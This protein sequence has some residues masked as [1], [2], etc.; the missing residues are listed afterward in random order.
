[1]GQF[2]GLPIQGVVV[3][4]G[5]AAATTNAS[6]RFSLPGQSKLVPL[7]FTKSGFVQRRTYASAGDKTWKIVPTSF[8]MA[9]F[10]DM[11]R[12]YTSS[13]IRWVRPVIVYIDTKPR[14]FTH[15]AVPQW[16]NEIH[17]QVPGFINSWS[18]GTIPFTIVKTAS[19]PADLTADA[20]VVHI[21]DCAA[22][23][24]NGPYIGYARRASTSAGEIVAGGVWLRY[25]NYPANPGKR[26]GILGHELGHVFGYAHMD[27][28]N[29][30]SLM[31]PSLGSKTDLKP[32]DVLA[33][34]FHYGRVPGNASPDTDGKYTRSVTLA[35]PIYWEGP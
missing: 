35:G 30:A 16:V 26:K 22:D 20:I 5:G 27:R 4:F 17:A 3:D 2:D 6:G 11:D 23:F 32:F 9:A 1:M 15:S 31:Y 18:A 25:K 19:P 10:N 8:D 14:C 29:P 21:S 28:S 12:G 33:S 13:T 24:A 7:K 34:R